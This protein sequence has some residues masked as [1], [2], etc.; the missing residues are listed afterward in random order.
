MATYDF[1]FDGLGLRAWCDLAKQGGD[2]PMSMAELLAKSRGQSGEELSLWEF[3]F[4]SMDTLHKACP[5]FPQSRDLTAGLEQAFLAIKSVL[6]F[7]LDPMTQP[8]SWILEAALVGFEGMPW[9]IMI[10]VLMGVVYFASKSV[11]LVGFVALCLMFLAAID[12]YD[13][14]IQTLAII[15]VCAVLCVLL[16]V[17]IGLAMSRNNTLQRMTIPVLDML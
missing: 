16:G 14:A 4:P 15:F 6:R 3:P 12:L 17:P 8:L 5:N 1:I 9:W 2:R 7:V 11:K 10:P 13:Y